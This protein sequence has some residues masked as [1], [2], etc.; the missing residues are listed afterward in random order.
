MRIVDLRKQIEIQKQNVVNASANPEEVKNVKAEIT[1][2]TSSKFYL[3]LT[4]K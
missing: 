2:L 4:L 3:L 1:S